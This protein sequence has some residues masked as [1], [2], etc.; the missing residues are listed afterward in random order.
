MFCII[1]VLFLL[2]SERQWDWGSPGLRY[3]LHQYLGLCGHMFKHRSSFLWQNELGHNILVQLLICG[4]ILWGQG[5]LGA[6]IATFMTNWYIDSGSAKFMSIT[7]HISLSRADFTTNI[8]LNKP[9]SAFCQALVFLSMWEGTYWR[10]ER[11]LEND[12]ALFIGVGCWPEFILSNSV[13]GGKYCIQIF[14]YYTDFCT[15]TIFLTLQHP[16][17]KICQISLVAHKR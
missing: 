17:Q 5:I 10:V 14:Y 3:Y 15:P 9:I 12:K 2:F 11:A 8:C 6:L 1:I 7:S 16:M 4:E 13:N